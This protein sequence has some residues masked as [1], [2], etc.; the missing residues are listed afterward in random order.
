MALPSWNSDR[1]RYAEERLSRLAALKAHRIPLVRQYDAIYRD[2]QLR[3]KSVDKSDYSANVGF[4]L[5]NNKASEIL[6]SMPKYDCVGLDKDG[7]RNSYVAKLAW[8]HH[9]RTDKVEQTLTK[10][11]RQALKFGSGYLWQYVQFST[12]TVKTPTGEMDEF[13]QFKYKE[14]EVI[15]ALKPHA[16]FVPWENFYI[17]SHDIDTATQMVVIRHWLRDDWENVRKGLLA[18]AGLSCDDVPHGKRYDWYSKT[19]N[20][21]YNFGLNEPAFSFWLTP[22]QDAERQK[23]VSELHFYDKA[24][25]EYLIVA[26]GVWINPLKKSS[27]TKTETVPEAEPKEAEESYGSYVCMPMPNTHKEL[28]GCIFTDHPLEDDYTGRGEFDVTYEDRKLIDAGL[29]LMLDATKAQ[30]GFVTIDPDSD[31]DEGIVE[32]GPD[33]VARVRRDEVGFF[34]P[35]PNLQGLQWVMQKAEDNIVTKTGND[36]RQLLHSSKE[37][38]SKTVAKVESEKK[39]VS[40]TLKEAAWSFF[41]RFARLRMADI[42]L[43]HSVPTTIT[44]RGVEVTDDGVANELNGGYGTFLVKPKMMKG[45]LLMLPS[46]E[47]MVTDKQDDLNKGL[48]MMQIMGSMVKE[49]GKP[50]IP[51]ENWLQFLKPYFD[52]DFD[53]LTQAKDSGKSPEKLMQEAGLMGDAGQQSQIAQS[54]GNQMMDPNWIPPSQRSGASRVATPASQAGAKPMLSQ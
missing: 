18:Q 3:P 25:D 38:A 23:W 6:A 36:Y 31:F 2:A 47:S 15:D 34:A 12:R 43:V 53:Q 30:M 48:Q 22:N 39:R 7:K 42:Q 45:K 44:V 1:A 10:V 4:A 40:L 27:V 54:S 29:S 16:E 51:S 32:W 52:A 17:N 19:A 41:E 35:T 14:E 13:G 50:V 49:D 9:W 11:V 46:I 5:V 26:N 37:S 8:D 33:R 21:G 24:E 28:P 20:A